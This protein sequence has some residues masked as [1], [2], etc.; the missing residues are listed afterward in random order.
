MI[1]SHVAG[2]V[3]GETRERLRSR[4]CPN[5]RHG[6]AAERRQEEGASACEN[7]GAEIPL[8]GP[9]AEEADD[10][11]KSDTAPTEGASPRV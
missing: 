7:C 9:A 1:H 4:L 2:R 5:C 10:G 8:A 11:A 6:H 3:F